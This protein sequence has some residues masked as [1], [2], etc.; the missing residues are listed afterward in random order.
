MFLLKGLIYQ[1]PHSIGAL[2][3][4]V[5]NVGLYAQSSQGGVR[6]ELSVTCSRAAQ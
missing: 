1:E 5:C 3:C 2:I 6:G 4:V